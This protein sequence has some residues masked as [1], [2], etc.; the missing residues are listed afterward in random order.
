MRFVPGDLLVTGYDER[1]SADR[2]TGH[3]RNL[4]EATDAKLIP[5]RFASTPRAGHDRFNAAVTAQ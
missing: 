4:I 2:V 1:E 3:R 5:S